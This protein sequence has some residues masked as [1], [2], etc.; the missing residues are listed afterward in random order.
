MTQCSADGNRIH[1]IRLVHRIDDAGQPLLEIPFDVVSGKPDPEIYELVS[2]ELE[3]DAAESLVLEDS[4]T[5]V[6]AA[7]GAGMW[8]IAVTTPFTRDGVHKQALL[9]P[10]WIVDDPEQVSEVVGPLHPG[11]R[12]SHRLNH[13]R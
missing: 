2:R 8:C 10:E 13:R 7:I 5:G 11:M 6:E 1:G 3:V 4:P 9:P 12:S